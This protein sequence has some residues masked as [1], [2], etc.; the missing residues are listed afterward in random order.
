MMIV[1][2]HT[3]RKKVSARKNII[4]FKFEILIKCAQL[5]KIEKNKVL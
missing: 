3:F 1:S 5:L 2:I 4:Y